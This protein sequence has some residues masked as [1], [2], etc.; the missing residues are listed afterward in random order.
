MVDQLWLWVLG[1]GEYLLLA[2]KL[3]RKAD[4]IRFG[5]H[6]FPRTLAAT[7][8]RSTERCRRH[9]RG[10]ERK[11]T[12]ANIIGPRP[13]ITDYKTGARARLTDTGQWPELPV[14]RNVWQF[15]RIHRR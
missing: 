12:A 1:K 2:S 9:H 6:M 8:T 15:Y 11:D 10:H 5:R 3:G 14:P 7:Q 4:P 13:S